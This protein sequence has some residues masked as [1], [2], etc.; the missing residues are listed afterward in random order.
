MY[1]RLYPKKNNSLFYA[2]GGSQ[3]AAS[4]LINT[5]ANPIMQLMDGNY[6]GLTALQFVISDDLAEKLNKYEYT[7]KLKLWDSGYVPGFEQMPPLTYTLSKNTDDF[8]EGSGYFFLGKDAVTGT[9]NYHFRNDSNDVWSAKTLIDTVVTDRWHDDLEFTIDSLQE[10]INTFYVQPLNP[11]QDVTIQ[12]AKYVFSRHTRT[13]YLPYIELVIDDNVSDS[14]QN[15]VAGEIVTGVLINEN[16]RDFTGVITCQLVDN[17]KVFMQTVDVENL[18][19]GIYRYQDSIP[20]NY[21]PT[22]LYEQWFLDGNKIWEELVNVISPNKIRTTGLIYEGQYF[23]PTSTYPHEII[24]W[25]DKP[26]MQ[27]IANARG[28]ANIARDYFEYRVMCD[29]GF[30][31]IPWQKVNS[32]RGTMWFN[33]D[34]SFFFPDIN[35]EVQVR[36]NV[37]DVIFTSE[38]VYKFKLAYNKSS[39][40]VSEFNASPYQSRDYQL[41]K[42]LKR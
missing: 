3:I 22:F 15:Y 37:N 9:S 26:N 28:G 17:K 1:L 33:F 41:Q 36:M 23:Y 12:R 14:K 11:S 5:G 13:I 6:Q 7:A 8:Q 30:E 27:I 20:E 34:T 32:Y 38:L 10:G 42:S 39:Q 25:G 2:Q 16:K 19:G 29:N 24:M 18:G 4:G 31:M 35:Y 21:V 40:F